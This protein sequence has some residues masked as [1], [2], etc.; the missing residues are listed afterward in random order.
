[1][2]IYLFLFFWKNRQG[3]CN[4]RRT[5][6]VHHMA[7]EKKDRIF[8]DVCPFV[9]ET[10]NFTVS[11]DRGRWSQLFKNTSSPVLFPVFGHQL[12]DESLSSIIF[13]LKSYFQFII[14]NSFRQFDTL[15]LDLFPLSL[16]NACI[17]TKKKNIYVWIKFEKYFLSKKSITKPKFMSGFQCSVITQCACFFSVL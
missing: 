13:I 10:N 5:K 6:K 4:N 14:C 17:C 2:Y 11:V 3:T 7:Q 15:S 16:L 8:S 1:M 9:V 12:M